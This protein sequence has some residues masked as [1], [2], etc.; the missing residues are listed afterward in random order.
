MKLRSLVGHSRGL[1]FAAVVALALGIGI[2][3]LMFAI[4]DGTVH[5]GLPVRD[6]GEIVHLERV[7]SPGGDRRTQFLASERA[8]LAGQGSLA[9]V[10]GYAQRQT[11]IA[12]P[13]LTPRRWPTVLVTPNTF[14]VLAVQPALG[15]TFDTGTIAGARPLV[16]SDDVWREQFASSPSAIG[17]AV[18]A[19]GEPAV[20]VGVMRPG[21]RFP[22]NHHVWA[23]M[24]EAAGT[25]PVQL[26]GR[27]VRGRSAEAAQAELTTRYQQVADGAAG[28]QA[29][30]GARIGV[31]PY[32]SYL[33]GP[34]VVQLLETMFW[35]G[36]GVLVI[37]CA[38][39]AN[40]LLARGLARRRDFAIAA[41]LGASRARLMRDRLLEGLAL[42]VPGALLGIGVTYAG[43]WAFTRAITASFPP[44][45]YWVA[46]RVDTRVLMF[47]VAVTVL[48]AL[49]AAALPAWRTRSAAISTALTDAARG[50]TSASL[51]R[52]TAGLIVVEI[53]L[54]AAV[55]V[56]GG[57]MG[58][59]IMRLSTAQYPFAVAD[60]R[61]GRL[62]LPARSYPTPDSRRMFY[63]SLHAALQSLAGARGA[64][65]GSSVP[66]ALVLPVPFTLDPPDGDP[67]R[68]P[69]ARPVFV[70]PGYFHALGVGL[71]G[72]RDFEAGDRED[73]APVAIVNQSFALKHARRADLIGQTI[74][75]AG[76]GPNAAPVTATI[77][78]VA[79][80][81]FV[82]NPRGEEPEAMYFPLFQ[83]LV[84]PDG[85]SMLARGEAGGG[86]LERAMQAAV[87]ALDPELPLDRVMSLSAFR[88]GAT[89]FYGVFGVLFLAFGMGALVLALVGVYAVMSF[90]ITRRRR[91]IGTRMAC[92]ATRGDIARMVLLEGSQ[93][94]MLGLLAGGLLAAWLTPRLALFL[95]QVSPRDPAIFAAATAVVAIV[96]LSACALPALRA[97][98]QN[99]NVCLRDD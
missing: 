73:R 63:L 86:S 71:I 74:T 76:A 52:L 29:D 95:F 3:A 10:A 33:Q 41:A 9:A 70:S 72:G 45:P 25:V 50:T 35:A 20:I 53:A 83:Q 14:E 92:G 12:G 37:A 36:V 43:A 18:R 16:I 22:V 96:G 32:T 26:W 67:A 85:I 75:V 55:L 6:A 8:L 42:A 39:V 57:L 78:G 65:L 80:D 49:A 81:L 59:G 68:W 28:A 93:R 98:R 60:V 7:P 40:L 11:N 31:A 24:D 54:A 69:Q 88:A 15:Q 4:V 19:N 94:L 46:V 66:F 34:Q 87:G 27:L 79:P 5:R 13:G 61:I 99:P 64:A 58:K 91:E 21:F 82:G 44:P 89:W 23:P 17:T 97:A 62:L 51:R 90:G 30:T 1:A 38:N 84:P 48:A 2:T 77:I 47:V 56:G